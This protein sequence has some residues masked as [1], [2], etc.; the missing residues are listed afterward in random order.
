M[1]IITFILGFLLIAGCAHQ[2]KTSSPVNIAGTWKGEYDTGVGD[3]PPML[4]IVNFKSKGET[5]TGN[6]CNA[7]VNPKYWIPLDNGKIE[8]NRISFT[9]WPASKQGLGEFIF[10]YKG[11]I[12][13]DEIKL[14]FKGRIAGNQDTPKV[15]RGRRAMGEVANQREIG[16]MKSMMGPMYDISGTEAAS[17]SSSSQKMTLIRVK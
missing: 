17:A 3:Q 9:T 12:E 7:T 8:G 16:S 13:G 4:I 11:N 10:K 14:T 2:S 5:L 1:K 15:G 6:M